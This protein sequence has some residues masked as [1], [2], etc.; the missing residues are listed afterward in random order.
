M[1]MTETRP[2]TGA[3]AA[4][5]SEQSDPAGLELLVGS[6]DHRTTGV[7]F[8]GFAL[9]FLV[10]SLV[11]RALVGID[12]LTDNGFLGVFGGLSDLTSQVGLVL[13][14]VV[15]L[16]LGLAIYVVPLQVGS[17][18]IAFPRA[19]SL[20]LWAWVL[21][22]GV[23]IASA[24]LKGGIG[25]GDDAAARLGNVSLGLILLA[26]GLATVA[27]MTTVVAHRPFGMG[28]AKVPLFSWSMLVGGAIW[29][30]SFGSAFAHVVVGQITHSGAQALATNFSN[31]LAWLLR[32]P[33]VYMIAIPVLGIAGDVV[34][35][36]ANRR[37]ANYFVFQTFI[38]A[39]A[40]LSFGAWVQQPTAVRTAVWTV[41]ALLVGLP[42]LGL[43]GGLADSL[44]HGPVKFDAAVVGSFV[45]LLL[46]LGAVAAGLLIALD[47]AGHGQ[48]VG[49][50]GAALS[51]SQAFF[52]VGAALVG[53]IAGLFGWSPLIFG[54]GEKK[55]AATGAV[56][57]TAG[58]AALLATASLVAGLVQLDG[59]DTGYQAFAVL[60]AIGAVV[61]LLGVVA[62]LVATLG[63]A[64]AGDEEGAEELSGL[65]LEWA[66]APRPLDAPP[67]QSAFP[68]LD[69]AEENA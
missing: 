49:F 21:G 3:A 22:S 48:L 26:L 12:V 44:R 25:G 24:A 17:P 69:D 37:L 56:L 13:L 38:G 57:L 50:N 31:G 18:A 10:I 47:N 53:A 2:E 60:G 68:L 34:A 28:L 30:L 55:G 58:G 16:L 66:G 62:T 54:R 15:P 4:T 51:A 23:F 52:A 43:L 6:G 32:A 20:S 67:V 35:R 33:T 63:A 42:V 29:V 19:V 14:G 61:A 1:A 7:V 11:V 41:V 64:R 9:L 39:F 40:V 5:A 27:V 46:L 59:K 8:I 36:A 65:T 45:S